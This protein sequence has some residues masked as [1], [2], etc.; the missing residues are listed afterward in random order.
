[1]AY[2]QAVALEGLTGNA[3]DV[4]KLP[5]GS[6]LAKDRVAAILLRGFDP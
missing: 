6:P 4:R 1:M 2:A 5:P 3:R